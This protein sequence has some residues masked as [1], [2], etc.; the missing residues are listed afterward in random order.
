[1]AKKR[2]GT[3]LLF[4][5]IGKTSLNITAKCCLYLMMDRIFGAD[6]DQLSPVSAKDHKNKCKPLTASGSLSQ[7][8]LWGQ[9]ISQRLEIQ[10]I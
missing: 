3:A 5:W 1:V 6:G 9:D 10:E 4:P 7:E 8:G 2:K